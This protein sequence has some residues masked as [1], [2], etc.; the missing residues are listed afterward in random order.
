MELFFYFVMVFS[1]S[2]HLQTVTASQLYDAVET[3]QSAREFEFHKQPIATGQRR[4]ITRCASVV[5]TALPRCW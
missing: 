2:G 4:A 5:M 3:C 1:A